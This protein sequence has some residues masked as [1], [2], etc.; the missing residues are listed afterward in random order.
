M[1]EQVNSFEINKENRKS[2]V[3]VLITYTA[4]IFLFVIGTV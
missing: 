4:A 3:R 1:S 2:W